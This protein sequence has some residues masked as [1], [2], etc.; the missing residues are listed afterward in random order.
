MASIEGKRGMPRPRPPF[1]AQSGLWGKPT[2]INNVKTYS[3]IPVIINEGADWY[4]SLGTEKSPGTAVFA[5]TGK[6]AN[7]GLV[8]VPM[9]TPLRTIIFEIG[10]GILGGK[11]FKAVQTGGPSG[12]C[13][14]ASFLDSPVDYE[15][16]AKAGSIMGSG[17][18][19]VLDEDTCMVDVAKYFLSFTMMES[20]GK[21]IPC[22]WGNKQLLDIL[23]DITNGRGRPEDIDLLIEV[24]EGIK[25]GSLCGLGQTSPNPVL[26]TIRYF[27]KEYEDHI[28]KH[29]CDAAVCKGLVDAPCSHT[30][31][32]GVNV[33]RYI[34]YI[35]E[36]KYDEA[37]AVIRESMPFPAV[38]GYV[39][40]HP[41][42]TRCRR[43]LLDEPIA[44][45]ELK[46]FAVDHARHF[47]QF[48][49][50]AADAAPPSGK[51]VAIIGAGPAGLTAAYYLIRRGGHAVTVYEEKPKA[52]GMMRY[53]IPRYRLPEHILDAEIDVIKSVG[54]DIRTGV[55]VDSVGSLRE[56][57]DAVFVGIG[58]Q[59]GARLRIPG[60]DTPGVLDCVDFLRDIAAGKKVSLGER[61][62]VVGGG[63][64]AIDA[65]RTALRLGAKE[66]AILYRRTQDEMPASEEEIQ[67]ALEEGVS[68]EY[69]V[70]PKD[71]HRE[72]G[73]LRLRCTR[74]QLGAMD[75]SGRRRPEP[76]PDSEFEKDYD[77]I[78]AAIGQ[79]PEYP[80][81]F[82]L[83]VERGIIQADPYNLETNV[84]G[85]FAGGDAVTGPAS[86][87][88]AI[89]AGKQAAIS[90]D[91]FLGGD[92]NIE[93]RFVP[94]E[95]KPEMLEI[96][97][98]EEKHRP[99]MPKTPVR[100]RLRG[101][102]MVERGLNR[103]QA[104][105]EAGRCLRC[106]L[107]ED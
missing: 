54:V 20:C 24:S 107:E 104:I 10:G 73:F 105:E 71:V 64:A 93:E 57:Y 61:V 103:K 79:V 27:R 43:G 89:A 101:F 47:P 15:T 97:E 106:D 49:I 35:A 3:T 63:N 44:I 46:R 68:I 14:P 38:C 11:K 55:R 74:M 80:E 17:G 18:M 45:R 62:A 78:I 88:E 29:H 75:S 76:I 37:V 85:V 13:L 53:G 33:P 8:E 69:L 100:K 90:I 82:E 81:S 9:G 21:C 31:P 66:S 83:A 59:A 7:S 48:P 67:E 42:E 95:E 23:E 41:C 56:E 30:C 98:E 2:N 22:R 5:L 40:F 6:V 87:I 39:C 51:R 26:S 77:T 19:V 96:E 70:S 99:A 92:G 58:A 102:K 52:G 86:V 60:E 32:A 36:E 94:P 34:R 28:M 91:R 1:P 25:A 72:N 50:D 84:T 65:S 4:K 12:G 16:L